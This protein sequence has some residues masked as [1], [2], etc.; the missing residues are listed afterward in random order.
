MKLLDGRTESSRTESLRTK[1]SRTLESRTLKS[2]TLKSRTLKP[3]TL[4]CWT[5]KCRTL[6]PGPRIIEYPEMRALNS[7]W[8]PKGLL[9]FEVKK[10]SEIRIHEI[11]HKALILYKTIVKLFT[12]KHQE[13]FIGYNLSKVDTLWT[14]KLQQK[15][16]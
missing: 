9:R 2:R 6:N 4:K 1:S 15:V 16:V 14:N 12:P 10:T 5:L 11:E 7:I 8:Y 3:R 13:Y